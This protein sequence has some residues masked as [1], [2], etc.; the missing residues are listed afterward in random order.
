MYIL[1]GKGTLCSFSM[2]KAWCA[3]INT[4]LL[5]IYIKQRYKSA[6]KC[7]KFPAQLSSSLFLFL[8][9]DGG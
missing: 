8:T 9:T 4:V 1:K 6:L 3:F 2:S 7:S 5:N